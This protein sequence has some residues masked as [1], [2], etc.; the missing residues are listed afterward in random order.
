MDIQKIRE[1]IKINPTFDNYLRLFQFCKQENKTEFMSFTV[2]KMLKLFP[3]EENVKRYEE[4]VR[5]NFD[6]DILWELFYFYKRS[7]EYNKALAVLNKFVERNKFAFMYI[8][9]GNFYYKLKRYDLAF[10]DYAQAIEITPYAEIEL[11]DAAFKQKLDEQRLSVFAKKESYSE[12]FANLCLKMG[13]YD[14]LI[15]EYSKILNS[16]S[17][18]RK[19]RPRYLFKRAEAYYKLGNYDVAIKDYRQ[20]TIINPKDEDAY[21]ECGWVCNDAGRFNHAIQNYSKVI[22]LNPNNS[23]A[24]FNRGEAYFKLKQYAAAI[25]DLDK[26]LEMDSADSEAHKLRGQC[27]QRLGNESK[28]QADF[29]KV[30]IKGRRLF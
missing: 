29:A 19:N 30:A 12:V 6:S 17:T 16:K 7:A 1:Q 8:K 11:P 15:E 21:F 2:K 20:I 10:A 18:R 13:R 26:Y 4:L 9:R 23:A 28:A 24:Y 3:V 25:A 14:L 27:H 5:N 22:E